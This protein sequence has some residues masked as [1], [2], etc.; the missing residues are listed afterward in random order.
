MTTSLQHPQPRSTTVPPA[1][2]SRPRP[3]PPHADTPAR[4]LSLRPASCVLRPASR[5]ALCCGVLRCDNLT[6]LGRSLIAGSCPLLC[7]QASSL[8]AL[9]LSQDQKTTSSRR[10]RRPPD[11]PAADCTRIHPSR[12]GCVSGLFYPVSLQGP[13]A[14]API[15]DRAPARKRRCISAQPPGI[16]PCIITHWDRSTNKFISTQ[17]TAGHARSGPSAVIALF[18]QPPPPPALCLSS[19]NFGRLLAR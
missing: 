2:V 3:R 8:S 7:S 13:I 14:A 4:W 5:G 19:R 18:G 15:G 9:R 12:C 16:T 1:S 6:A 10:R 11:K 17:N